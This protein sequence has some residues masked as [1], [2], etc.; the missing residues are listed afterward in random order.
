M[1]ELDLLVFGDMAIDYFYEVDSF[2]KLNESVDVKRVHKFYGGMGANT[3]IIAS[4]LGLQTGLVSVVGSDAEDYLSYMRNQGIKQHLKGIFGDTTKSIF[5]KNND[6]QISFFYKG[7]AKK[8]DEL[9]P[10]KE[11]VDA[12]R[13]IYMSRTYLNLQERVSRLCKEKF[14]VYNPGYGIFKFKNV[15]KKF[16]RILKRVNV[17]VLNRHEFEHMKSIGFNLDFKLGPSLFLITKGGKGCYIHSKNLYETVLVFK[18]KEIDTSGAGDAFNAGFI[19][20]HLKGFNTLDSVKIG[21]STA[22]FIVERWGCQTNLPTWDQVMERY[23][24]IK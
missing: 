18:T 8:V 9:K 3:A 5:F 19:T 1:N 10:D 16:Y 7:I 11:L 23:K 13:C 20:A 22:S 21:N 24:K 15:P 4:N 14:L 12:S 17:L 2:P 6:D